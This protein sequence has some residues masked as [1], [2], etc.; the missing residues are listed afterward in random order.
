M[1]TA[2]PAY[3]AKM[4]AEGLNDAAIAAFKYNFSVLVSGTSTMIPES[5]IGPVADL[6]DLEHLSVTP[7]PS[8]LK[9][10]VVLKLNGGLGTGMGLD[11]AKSLLPVT[12]SNTFLDLIAKQVGSMRADFETDL[13]FMLMNSF[14][15]SADTLS[16]LSKYPDLA[17]GDL[18]LE[19]VQ[20][21]APKVTESDFSPA[22]WPKDRGHEWCPPGHGD[23][24][25]AMLGSGT[26]DKLLSKGFKYMFV[27][28]SDNL[29]A[30][31]DL[32]ILTYFATSG[33]PFMMEVAQ[34]TDADKKGG[35][36]AKDLA[37]GGLTLRE[38]AQCPDE[39]EKAFQDVSKYTYFNTNNLWVDLVALKATF[40]K[41][42]GSIP[43]P[44]MKN[45]KTVDPRDKKSTKV[46]QLET[47]MGAA[48]SCFEGA[49]ALKIPRSRFAPV[50]TTNDLLALRSDAY[51]L[52][53]DNR[54]ELAPSRNGVPPNIK[55]DGMYKFVDAM[56]TLTPNG[57]PSLINCDKLVIEGP[58]EFAAGVVIKGNVTIK[59]GTE[60]RKVVSAGTYEN[61]TLDLTEEASG[62]GDPATSRIIF[63]RAREIFDSRGNP[64][65]EV[66]L[67]TEQAMF[68]AAVPSGAST[69]IYEALELRDNDKSRL[70][71][72]G[73]LKAVKNVNEIIAP[74]LLG[75][76][77]TQ[78]AKIDRL[79]VETM[80]GS[81]N[82]WGWSKSKL[83]ANA[84]LAVSMAV[85]RAGATASRMPLYQYIAKLAGKP[86]DNFVLPVPSFN[87]I[88]GGS[89][90]GN[91]LA[92]QEFMILPVGAQS[93]KEAMIIGAEVYHALKSV[94][95]KKYG[96]DACN[97][98][99]EGG[100]AP[101]VQDNDEALDVLT[102]AVQKSGHGDKV[103]FGTDVAAS[104][105][106]DADTK[107]YD[108]DFK[109][110]NSPPEM[111]VSAD[112]LIELYQRWVSKYP[113]VSIEDPFDQDDWDAYK[114]LMASVGQEQQIVGD[115][116]LVTNPSRIQ[117][118]LDVGA[119][120]ALLLKV[121][122][123]GS[124]S[125]ALEAA[126]MAQAA[127]WGVMVS[128]RSGETEDCFIADL[129]VG[130]RAGQIKTGAP[131]R[132]ERLAKY[133]QLLRIEEELGPLC[134]Y[135]GKSF[136]RPL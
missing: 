103:K 90:A 133:N 134:R 16:F 84:I 8:L 7:E 20:N 47:A 15:T 113:F 72:K 87:V 6:P 52:T 66:D 130:L 58:V 89:H 33:A 107:T 81:Q 116:L 1:D 92:C 100:F 95:K 54:I 93:F 31:M 71:G 4:K 69:G 61:T 46:V 106:Y 83:G 129:A 40:D 123:I 101:S 9:S 115:D 3:E 122:Q 41:H 53:P 43:L 49:I 37:T 30:T 82:E 118:A 111:K 119:C 125:E 97:V 26:L 32:K 35:H 112:K 80:D 77:V 22:D 135:A 74:K 45:G 75:M 19:F 27:S 70:L 5:A 64:T 50:K 110:P 39:D 96:Q 98:G 124:I 136:R 36:L 76:D 104:E 11:K 59:N 60:E 51:T 62:A 78:Q 108:L 63:L 55:L 120:N 114:S 86:T 102:E 21:K 79:M 109:N 73:V 56:D 2:W 24:Y 132:S 105:F 12:G 44:V 67:A 10:T 28:N 23:L 128:H 99:D 38:S 121:N 117:K 48:I 88:N 127:G 34:R 29:G 68:R 18:G 42:G 126:R 17:S 94:I 85:C 131:C 65:V 91:R 25:P 13:A 14:S 57:T